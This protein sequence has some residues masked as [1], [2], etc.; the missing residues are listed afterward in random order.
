MTFLA[1]LSDSH[2]GF[3]HR[4][5]SERLSDYRASFIE[6]VDKALALNP[7]VLVLGGDMLHHPKPDPVSMRAVVQKLLQAAERTQVVCSIGNHEIAGHL[8]T[9]Y[10]PIFSDL[11]KNIHV[12]STENPRVELHLHGK[13]ICFHGF[14]F[15]RS[16]EAA[17]AEIAKISNEVG[18]A[19]ANILLLHQAVE[20]YLS[21][22]E[23]S[24]KALRECAP[25]Y[26]LILLGH[27]HKH[28]KIA[29][30]FDV[31]PTYYIG[32]TE[33]ISFNEWENHT[34]F[35]AFDGVDFQNPKFVHVNSAQMRK[36]M[37][38]LDRSTPKE[39]NEKINHTIQ[40]NAGAKLLS[41]EVS[42]EIAGDTLDVKTDW[43]GD[44]PNHTILEV[45]VTPKSDERQITLE[46]VELSADTIREYFA[47]T[48]IAGEEELLTECVRLF[49][50]YGR[51]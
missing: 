30:V 29:E 7:A 43:G 24:L 18:S 34:G 46:R 35:M 19:D 26:N 27:V 8:G 42:A 21:P 6:A 36:V 41:I 45:N 49:E 51:K 1:A 5:K 11:H 12:L 3:R 48:G 25:K 17:E 4:F 10:Q 44:Y 22:F 50:E 20:R 13:K 40:S 9:A 47:K 23:L 38:E 2:L 33:R 15:L 37:I 39:I 14:Q 28:Q 31:T 32:S 16:R